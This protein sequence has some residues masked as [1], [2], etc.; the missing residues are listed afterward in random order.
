MTIIIASLGL[1]QHCFEYSNIKKA[2]YSVITLLVLKNVKVQYWA[3]SDFNFI[4]S[5]LL[6]QLSNID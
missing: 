6:I 3:L 1:P 5:V 4:I 2:K